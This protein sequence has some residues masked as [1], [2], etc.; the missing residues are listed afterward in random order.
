MRERALDAAVQLLGGQ[1]L[2]SLTHRRVDDAAGLPH[3]STSNYF[4]T[5]EAL[6]RGVIDRLVQQDQQ[7]WEQFRG[8]A[9]AT[10]EDLVEAIV[11]VIDAATGAD[12][13][14]TVARYTLFM[15]TMSNP[16]LADPIAAGRARIE[17]WG[18]DV[19][20][21]LGAAD[22]PAAARLLTDLADGLILRR[23]TM[24]SPIDPRPEFRALV[25]ALLQ[26]RG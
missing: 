19:L 18:A 2:R 21:R 8:A 3:G 1:G 6:L 23:L 4:R 20:G 25:G 24:A 15:E 12:R 9:A 22:P 11:A 26:P 7:Q 10:V 16:L 5:R 17:S 14:R 13:T